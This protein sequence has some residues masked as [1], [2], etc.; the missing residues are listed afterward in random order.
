MDFLYAFFFGA[1][2]AGFVYSKMERR[3]GYGN[4]SNVW[5][6]TGIVFVLSLIVFYTILKFILNI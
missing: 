2:A 6:V 3:I 5:M 1:G 4:T